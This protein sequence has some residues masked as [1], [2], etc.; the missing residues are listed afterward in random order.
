MGHSAPSF[1]AN[2]FQIWWVGSASII[3]V[4][5]GPI[6]T[7]FGCLEREGSQSGRAV[8]SWKK[9]RPQN[10]RDSVKK[11]TKPTACP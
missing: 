11:A 8:V 9:E 1:T 5:I 10:P 3:S 7:T 4:K 2:Y 6:L